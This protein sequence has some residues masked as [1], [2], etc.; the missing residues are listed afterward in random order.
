MGQKSDL[1]LSIKPY[2]AVT[3]SKWTHIKAN[4]SEL[5]FENNNH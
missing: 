3:E 1:V 4:I 5:S 2:K